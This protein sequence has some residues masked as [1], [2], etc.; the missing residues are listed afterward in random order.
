MTPLTRPTEPLTLTT[1]PR[2]LPC[3]YYEHATIGHVALATLR[4]GP[5]Q[6]AAGLTRTAFLSAQMEAASTLNITTLAAAKNLARPGK[7]WQRTFTQV[8]GFCWV[9]LIADEWV[10]PV[11]CML[12]TYPTATDIAKL[13]SCFRTLE[14][15]SLS[16]YRSHLRKG[17]SIL[18]VT[19]S[20]KPAHHQPEDRLWALG[21]VVGSRYPVPPSPCNQ[22]Q[23]L[24]VHPARRSQVPPPP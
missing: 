5:A 17:E 15:G 8:P 19:G 16:I 6:I 7:A 13:A 9:K 18:H 14:R 22:D 1:M 10:V 12:G 4:I 20:D 11:V 2:I 21:G 23:R 3:Q 24:N